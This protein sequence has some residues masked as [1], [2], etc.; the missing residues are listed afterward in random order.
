MPDIC[1]MWVNPVLPSSEVD[2]IWLVHLPT[3]SMNLLLLVHECMNGSS[4]LFVAI[5]SLNTFTSY[6]EKYRTCCP[7]SLDS[8][9]K[10]RVQ[11]EA[12]SPR[13]I[14]LL[15]LHQIPWFLFFETRGWFMSVPHC[16]PKLFFAIYV[17]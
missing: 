14:C 15:F 16:T 5:F 4:S 11:I 12:L 1:G 6:T 8:R 7:F 17:M 10:M 3:L 13:I 9:N 2:D